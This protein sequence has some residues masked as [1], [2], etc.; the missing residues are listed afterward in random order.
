MDIKV[1]RVMPVGD[2]KNREPGRPA[3]V[4]ARLLAIRPPRRR[5]N[6]RTSDERRHRGSPGRDPVHGK[7]L[8][9]MVPDGA[10]LPEDLATGSY[11]VFINFLRR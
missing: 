6:E 10:H 4:E 9:L 5:T 1:G 3:R 2:P 7:V 11:R 8:V